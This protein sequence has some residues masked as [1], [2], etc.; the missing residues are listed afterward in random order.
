MYK[1]EAMLDRLQQ[2]GLDIVASG[3]I[4]FGWTFVLVL[5]ILQNAH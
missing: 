3:M 5:S 4:A 2:G 1:I